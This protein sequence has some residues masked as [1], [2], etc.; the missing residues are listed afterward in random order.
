MIV[1]RILLFYFSLAAFLLL[2]ALPLPFLLD[3][4]SPSPPFGLS[5]QP[6]GDPSYPY[7]VVIEGP[8][9]TIQSQCPPQW[10]GGNWLL[11]APLARVNNIEYS[12]AYLIISDGKALIYTLPRAIPPWYPDICHAAP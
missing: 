6:Y 5:V 11:F 3:E 7:A 1:S 12:G 2:L 4:H 8:V 10:T 9:T